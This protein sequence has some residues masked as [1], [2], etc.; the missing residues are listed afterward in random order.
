MVT[1]MFRDQ[2]GSTVEVYIDNIVVKIKKDERHVAN[3]TKAFEILRRHKLHLNTNKCAFGVGARKFLEYMITNQGI[4]VNPDQIRAI[5]QLNP[6]SNPKNMQ[7]LT[8]MIVA[9]NCFV[10]RLVDRCKLFFQLLKK[11]KGFQR[12]E[13]CEEAFQDLK[14]YLVSLPILSNPKPGEDLYMYLAVSDHLV[15]VVLLKTQGGV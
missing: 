1:R 5:Q 7:K 2:I 15:S 10:L 14:R 3:L 12:T 9:M 11:W 4:E 8:S 13:E 6:P